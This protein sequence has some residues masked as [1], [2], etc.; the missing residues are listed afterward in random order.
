MVTSAALF[1]SFTAVATMLVLLGV[2]SRGHAVVETVAP[3][4]VALVR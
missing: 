2:Y 1:P 4:V 3:S